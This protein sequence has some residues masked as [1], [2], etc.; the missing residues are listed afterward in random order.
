MSEAMAQLSIQSFN[1]R[2]QTGNSVVP[3]QRYTYTQNE[4]LIAIIITLILCVT[5]AEGIF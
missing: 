1:Q 3:E 2:N 4:N 5:S